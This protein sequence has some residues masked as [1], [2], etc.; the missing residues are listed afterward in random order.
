MARRSTRT[1][2]NSFSTYELL[3]R[4]LL[5]GL[6]VTL[7]AGDAPT[8]PTARAGEAAVRAG[9]RGLTGDPSAERVERSSS[10]WRVSERVRGSREE[11]L[12]ERGILGGSVW[13]GW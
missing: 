12:G 5:T 9:F 11:G 4:M 10:A 2:P 13:R 3:L 8:P 7:R 6:R 1:L